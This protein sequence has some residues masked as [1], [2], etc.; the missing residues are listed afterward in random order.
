MGVGYLNLCF[1]SGPWLVDLSLAWAIF[2]GRAV[3]VASGRGR[4]RA[5]VAS[6]LSDEALEAVE[7]VDREDALSHEEVKEKFGTEP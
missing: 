4:Y 2:S 7:S 3:P 5:E 6:A 1:K